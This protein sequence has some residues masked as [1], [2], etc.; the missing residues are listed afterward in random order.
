MDNNHFF[1]QGRDDSPLVAA[2]HPDL[3]EAGTCLSVDAR[4][5]MFY[6][7]YYGRGESRDLALHM[8]LE[9]GK[10]IWKGLRRVLEWH[11]GQLGEIQSLLD[12]AAGYGRVT[13]HMTTDLPPD[14]IWISEIDPGAVE[15][16]ENTFGVHGLR[17]TPESETFLPGRDFS[18]VLVSSLFTH[19]PEA[20]FLPWLERLLS[21]VREGG[22]LAFS[23]HDMALAPNPAPGAGFLFHPS[24][25]SG[26]LSNEEYGSTWVTEDY[27]RDCLAALASFAPGGLQVSRIPRGLA[28]FQDLYV[29]T[30]GSGASCASS[31]LLESLRGGVDGFVEECRLDTRRRL[32]LQG[33]M[34][35]RYTKTAVREVRFYI[36]GDLA[37]RT[38]ALF[39]RPEVAIN[40]PGDAGV[41]QGWRAELALPTKCDPSVATLRIAALGSDGFLSTLAEGTIA[42]FV[43][44][45]ALYRSL[46]RERENAGLRETMQSEQERFARRLAEEET[47]AREL[48]NEI[49]QLEAR[50]AAMR[51]SRFWKL[52]D[53]WFALKR[54]LRLTT[55][56]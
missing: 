42:S 55:E 30:K 50:I 39:D 47:R 29:V 54:R 51:A 11:F 13:R 2:L 15:F 36:D 43:T 17:S 49:H 28:S 35:D 5:E 8:Y 18:C 21:L 38:E 34:I 1:L 52:R 27:V 48:R 46:E 25:E 26:S 53:R 7:F 9:S 56:P 37:G 44:R 23:V 19:L 22:L 32:L 45:L 4:D 20:R 14:R 41:G 33:W 12:F 40:F 24:S 6:V 31:M 16:Q 10:H 3:L